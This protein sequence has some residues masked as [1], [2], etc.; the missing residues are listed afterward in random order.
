[1]KQKTPVLLPG[2]SRIMSNFGSNL[3]LA[4][5]RRR[6]SAEQVS[7]RAHISRSTLWLVEK[8]SPGVAMGTYVQVLFVLGL[9]RDLTAVGRDDTLGRKLQDAQLTMKERAPKKVQ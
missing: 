7:E 1:M 6:L 5:K 8:G 9:E 3:K 2:A 4:R